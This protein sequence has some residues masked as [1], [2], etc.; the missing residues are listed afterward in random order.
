M[1]ISFDPGSIADYRRFLAVKSLPRYA[2]RGTIASVPD[3]Y[4]DRLG[5]RSESL[6]DTTRFVPSPWLFDYQRDIASLAVTKR[7]FAVFAE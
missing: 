3:E 2:F 1:D 7:K 5:V 4:A 6:R